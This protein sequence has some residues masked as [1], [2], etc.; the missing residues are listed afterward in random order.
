MSYPDLVVGN[1]DV[2]DVVWTVTPGAKV[3]GRVTAKGGGPIADAQVTISA[4]FRGQGGG[5]RTEADG[6]FEVIGISPG[7][8]SAQAVH[9]LQPPQVRGRCRKVAVV[10]ESANLLYRLAG[11]ATQLCG[12]VSE[13]VNAASR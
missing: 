6:T 8:V 10:E 7:E 2:E 4:G 3:I 1:S 9:P 12:A 13:H 5:A 11:V